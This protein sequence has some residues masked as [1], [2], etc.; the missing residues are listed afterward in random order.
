MYFFE[1]KKVLL[2]ILE[3]YHGIGIF[4]AVLEVCTNTN[5]ISFTLTFNSLWQ[6]CFSLFLISDRESDLDGIQLL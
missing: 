2:N 6:N 1:N 5:D 3:Q 4:A